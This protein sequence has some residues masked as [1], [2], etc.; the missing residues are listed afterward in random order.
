[1]GFIKNMEIK[2]LSHYINEAKIIKPENHKEGRVL[3]TMGWPLGK[4]AG[5]GSFVYHAEKNQ[6][7]LGFCFFIKSKNS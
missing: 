6:I 7:F 4:N 2:Q 3:H 5:G 1:M